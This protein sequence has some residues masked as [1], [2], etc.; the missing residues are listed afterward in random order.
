MYSRQGV[1]MQAVR[2]FPFMVCRLERFPALS[3]TNHSECSFMGADAGSAQASDSQS[4]GRM[5]FD[6]M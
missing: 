2:D 1:A 6:L 5:P 3:F 4:P